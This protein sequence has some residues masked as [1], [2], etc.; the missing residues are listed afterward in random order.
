M[1][2]DQWLITHLDKSNTGFFQNAIWSI[3]PDFPCYHP[4]FPITL[5][6]ITQSRGSRFDTS[7]DESSKFV[8]EPEDDSLE[9]DYGILRQKKC[10]LGDSWPFIPYGL[11]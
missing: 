9:M 10:S 2:Y 5:A 1:P 7:N 3:A 4:V 11:L 8:E 6:S